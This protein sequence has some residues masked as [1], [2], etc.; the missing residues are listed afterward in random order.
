MK[1]Y[2][3]MICHSETLNSKT[4]SSFNTTL[5]QGTQTISATNSH[6]RS[7]TQNSENL[8]KL[9]LSLLDMISAPKAAFKRTG[10]PVEEIL[11]RA[12]REPW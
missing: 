10:V 1:Q 5:T 12:G 2:R 6:N 8:V 7:H 4:G 3:L 11:S 9:A